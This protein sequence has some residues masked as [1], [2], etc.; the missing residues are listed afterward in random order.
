[1]MDEKSNEIEQT[2][3]SYHSMQGFVCHKKIFFLII[4]C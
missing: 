1:M 2:A 4:Y 3:L